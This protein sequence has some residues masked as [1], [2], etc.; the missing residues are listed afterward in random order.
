M[1]PYIVSV[2]FTF[3]GNNIFLPINDKPKKSKNLHH[4]KR[5]KNK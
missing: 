2:M 3:D 5:V 1:E 4:L